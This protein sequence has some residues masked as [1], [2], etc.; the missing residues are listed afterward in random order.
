MPTITNP[1]HVW[2]YDLGLSG[3]TVTLTNNYSDD[4]DFSGYPTVLARNRSYGEFSGNPIYF[5][6]T[7]DGTVQIFTRYAL[8]KFTRNAD[9]TYNQL[10]GCENVDTD[11][12]VADLGADASDAAGGTGFYFNP[13]GPYTSG[14][15]HVVWINPVHT[16]DSR[17]LVADSSGIA[18]PFGVGGCVLT[19]YQASNLS[20]PVRLT[21]GSVNYEV[22][23]LYQALQHDGT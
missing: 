12:F 9:G 2:G 5:A 11:S 1:V 16:G 3:A 7:S 8:F 14:R 17:V 6:P 15:K 19:F 22:W 23:F 13:A 4:T 20:T 10:S 21:A 18:S